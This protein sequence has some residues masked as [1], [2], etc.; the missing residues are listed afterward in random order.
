MTR[1]QA[2][3]Y[4]RSSGY[5]E[6]QINKVVAALSGQTW[7]QVDERLPEITDHHTSEPC[8]VWCKEGVYGFA[9]LEENIFGQVGWNCEREDEY[10][11]PL[12]EVVAWMPLPTYQED[13]DGSN[14]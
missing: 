8:V 10:H 4:L 3:N 6:E 12:G 13:T 11:T 9:Q 1:K 14:S 5:S 2:I 7:I